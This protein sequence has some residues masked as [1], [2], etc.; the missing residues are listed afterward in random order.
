M[1]GFGKESVYVDIPYVRHPEFLDCKIMKEG[2][3]I[4]ESW[5]YM[6]KSSYFDDDETAK[7]KRI[8]RY[9]EHQQQNDFT[10]QRE[11][12]RNYVHELDKRRGTDFVKTF[13]EFEE[14]YNG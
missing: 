4:K 3:M 11:D 7:M 8:Y 5:E 1:M 6:S 9:W 12:L 10:K 13:P 14:Y 2:H